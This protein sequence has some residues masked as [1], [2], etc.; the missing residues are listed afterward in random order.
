MSAR[1]YGPALPDD[2]VVGTLDDGDKVRSKEASREARA[3]QTAITRSVIHQVFVEV[4][5]IVTV[6]TPIRVE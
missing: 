3:L 2:D 1:I 5:R 4:H 6:M